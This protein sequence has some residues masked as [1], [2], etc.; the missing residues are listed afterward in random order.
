MDTRFWGPD[1]WRMLHS[2]AIN[3]PERP[4]QKQKEL[5]KQFYE[6]LRLV[7]PCIYC[8]NSFIVFV[9]DLPID[10]YL[11]NKKTLSYW[12][13]L[14]HNKV[15]N[16]L[17]DQNL[18]VK[19]SNGF[20]SVYRRYL[21]N[22]R[23]FDELQAEIPVPGWDFIYS[24]LF[25]YPTQ[26]NFPIQEPERQLAF[27]KFFYLLAEVIPF[28]RFKLALKEQLLQF[29]IENYLDRASLKR[30]GYSLEQNYCQKTQL[31]CPSYKERSD[32]VEHFRAGCTGKNDT[33]PT[34]H[35]AD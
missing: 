9:N 3:Y 27:I 34:C 16:K 11:Q 25:N 14:M 28:P 32:F 8:R 19:Y 5:Y 2:I 17:S 29:P 4:T 31:N 6:N 33:K 13:Y 30:W 22:V 26:A 35:A 21:D 24:V 15:N 1:G 23:R 20:D 10:D 18:I 12:V 7:L